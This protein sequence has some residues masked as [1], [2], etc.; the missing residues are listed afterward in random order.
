MCSS[1][2]FRPVNP[3]FN[4]YDVSLTVRHCADP[5]DGNYS[6]LAFLADHER[7]GQLGTDNLLVFYFSDGDRFYARYALRD[8]DY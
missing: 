4:A 2:L 8:R 7:D 6:G 1:D 3:H 5:V